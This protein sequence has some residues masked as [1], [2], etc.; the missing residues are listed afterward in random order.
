MSSL[1]GFAQ[2]YAKDQLAELGHRI[3]QFD[4]STGEGS[5]MPPMSTSAKKQKGPQAKLEDLQPL[6]GT[7]LQRSKA[8]GVTSLYDRETQISSSAAL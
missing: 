6:L 7:S 8:V 2:Q 4:H 5:P 1:L 3:N